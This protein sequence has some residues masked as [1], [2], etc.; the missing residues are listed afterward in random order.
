MS[1]AFFDSVSCEHGVRGGE[2]FCIQCLRRIGDDRWLKIER[3]K[4][5]LGEVAALG[6]TCEECDPPNTMATYVTHHPM[7]GLPIFLCD[8]HAAET[9]EAYR[10]ALSKGCGPQPPVE[11]HEQDIAVQIALQALGPEA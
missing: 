11:P 2:Q 6:D 5:A 4:R 1:T 7:H 9:R 8:E 3:L 10:K